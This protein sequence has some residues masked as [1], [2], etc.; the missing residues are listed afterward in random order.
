[1]R[2]NADIVFTWLDDYINYL[3][4]KR[5]GKFSCYIYGTPFNYVDDF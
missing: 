1:M 2:Y 3:I 4:L 5:K